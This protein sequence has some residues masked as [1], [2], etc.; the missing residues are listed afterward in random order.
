MRLYVLFWFYR[1]QR[2]EQ[3]SWG[4]TASKPKTY[5]SNQDLST[6]P[7]IHALNHHISYTAFP[8]VYQFQFHKSYS[9][10]DV[11]LK[12]NQNYFFIF[13]NFCICI[14]FIFFFLL[15]NIVLVLPYINMNPPWVYTCSPSWNPLPHPSPYHPSGSS[16]CTSPKHPVSCIKPGLAIHFIYDIIHVS[17][18]PRPLPQSPKDCSIHLCLFCCLVYWV[19]IT[20]FLNSIYMH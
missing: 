8:P 9:I 14:S 17:S 3:F 16:Q 12:W 4:H 19:I 20:I 2:G 15:Y 5:E 13:L 10:L 11:E 18:Y 6:W 7:K 1:T